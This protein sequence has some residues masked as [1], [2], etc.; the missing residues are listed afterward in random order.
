[1]KDRE[2]PITT[3]HRWGKRGLT[4]THGT[5]EEGGSKILARLNYSTLLTG[6]YSQDSTRRTLL[7]GLPN[8]N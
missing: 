6:L 4:D 1:M 2:I 3:F 8:P 7:V 5:K